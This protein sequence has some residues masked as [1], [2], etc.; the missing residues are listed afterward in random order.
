M[1]QPVLRGEHVAWVRLAMQQLLSTAT[2][3]NPAA[4]VS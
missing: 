2:L 4:Q 1:K 3:A